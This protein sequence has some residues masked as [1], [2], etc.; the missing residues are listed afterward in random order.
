MRV[1]PTPRGAA[2]A[3]MRGVLWLLDR[4]KL[5]FLLLVT[6]A[7]PASAAGL[8][9]VTLNI[10]RTQY[11]YYHDTWI[12]VEAL[13]ANT[14][15]LN[16]TGLVLHITARDKATGAIVY[17]ADATGPSPW[18]QGSTCAL[19]PAES[20]WM[21]AYVPVPATPPGDYTI[22]ATL[23]MP[24]DSNVASSSYDVTVGSDGER[25]LQGSVAVRSN[26][27]FV[28]DTQGCDFSAVNTTA[29]PVGQW[30]FML[31]LINT[32]TNAPVRSEQLI[33]NVGA[34]ATLTWHRDYPTA[35][36]PPG[37]YACALYVARWDGG[38]VKRAGAAFDLLARPVLSADI[39]VLPDRSVYG[40]G[41]TAT[42]TI[43]A[44]NTSSSAAIQDGIAHVEVTAPDGRLIFAQDTP[45]ATLAPGA[46]QTWALN[47]S[48]VNPLAGH[49]RVTVV[50][51][52][53][54]VASIATGT[55]AFDVVALAAELSVGAER[56]VYTS[57]ERVDLRVAARNATANYTLQGARAH[58]EVRDPDGQLLLSQDTP[59]VT[60][61]PAVTQ[62]WPLTLQLAGAKAGRYTITST[63]STSA[64]GV[65]A[66]ASGAFDVVTPT[67][68]V[69]LT[70]DAPSY[71]IRAQVNL[72]VVAANT[73]R[74]VTLA[75]AS[76]HVEVRGPDGQL[77]A[78]Q[79]TPAADMATGTSRSTRLAFT[80]HD[81]PPGR[82][83]VSG[84]L[85]TPL[86]PDIARGTTA[87]NV[88]NMPETALSGSVT[89]DSDVVAIGTDAG[90]GYSVANRSPFGLPPQAIRTQLLSTA[91]QVLG[92]GDRSVTL[93][94]GDAVNWNEHYSTSNVATGRYTCVLAA[95]MGGAWRE[96]ARAS[97]EVVVP[98]IRIS[99]SLGFG[100]HGRLLALLDTVRVAA[101]T[102]DPNRRAVEPALPEQQAYL[103]ALL[104]RAGW[105]YTIANDA[106]TF[107]RELAS[108]AYNTYAVMSEA[109]K[110][111]V[112]TTDALVA[113][114]H[115]GA[116]L[117]DAGRHDER[118][119]AVDEALGIKYIGKFASASGLDMLDASLVPQR[120]ADYWLV[121]KT[122]HFEL[123][124]AESLARVLDAGTEAPAVTRFAFG[125]GKSIT[126][127]FDLLAEATLQR[128]GSLFEDLILAGLAQVQPVR[129]PAAGR[130]LPLR[131][132][133]ANEGIATDGRVLI[134]LPA[135][136]RVA[137]PGQASL[138]D[139][140]VLEWRYTLEQAA[141]GT[142]DV[143][144]VLPAAPD[145]LT[146][147]ALVQ[148][149]SGSGYQDY[150]NV[151]LELHPVVPLP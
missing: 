122:I 61:A 64:A 11:N 32:A 149:A 1:F 42:L 146:I 33:G 150:T 87:F 74:G 100:N 127:G 9:S 140:N 70:T 102:I 117:L 66:S 121:D 19:L 37:T 93:A 29:Y 16:L 48:L 57:R 91:G 129:L 75:S 148:T 71:G 135:G 12:N 144:V 4:V 125:T 141:H 14:S 103:E 113:A 84:V 132:S 119:H 107:A 88:V 104:K 52:N 108:G 5:L 128:E 124:G 40:P 45:A 89:V 31:S 139:G 62:T 7:I 90:C 49:Y 53:G 13:V 24:G 46:T 28:G 38:Y 72:D 126:A 116:G 79:D 143:W 136:V 142:L 106:S 56:S 21:A 18:C 110:L 76:T 95:S 80:L 145:T 81:A 111:D 58:V 118:N 101:L 34:S 92:G 3:G 30:P 120:H 26:P 59:A 114:V 2:R 137:D 86:T 69:G 47:T 109:I 27:L 8:A 97:F 133:L 96:L 147:S 36:L 131:L 25:V 99:A 123:Q 68:S 55:A 54:S 78:S 20:V 83:T 17:S 105:S 63:L 67:G 6:V 134:R 73:T 41:D 94:G 50:L 115:G 112:P 39:S 65:V 60:L 138:Q 151:T 82:Y 44:R 23:S 15:T 35:A 10:D 77:F 51:R 22:N 43:T 85:G 98:P 130:V